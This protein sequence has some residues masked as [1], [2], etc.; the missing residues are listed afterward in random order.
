[1]KI[2]IIHASSHPDYKK[3]IYEIIRTSA[4]V[5]NHEIIFPHEM[6]EAS[7]KS[8]GIISSSDLI[9]AEVSYPSIGVGVE[10][11]WAEVDNRKIL[12][13]HK[14]GIK[15]SSSLSVIS[16]DFIEYTTPDD[17][18]QK[19]SRWIEEN[20]YNLIKKCNKDLNLI[21]QK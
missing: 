8:K 20:D 17:M 15:P 2:Y 10:L 1:M 19:L 9:I 14:E 18:V 13:I 4:L 16:S 11:G 6:S 3:N 5:E 12:F 7:I 21:V